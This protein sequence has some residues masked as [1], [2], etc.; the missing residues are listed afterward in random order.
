MA[1]NPYGGLT[2]MIGMMLRADQQEQL[3]EFRQD[4]L[5][6]RRE[7][8][9]KNRDFENRR[10]GILETRNKVD[11]D[12]LEINQQVEEDRQKVSEMGFRNLEASKLVKQYVGVDVNGIPLIDPSTGRLD[13]NAIIKGLEGRHPEVDALALLTIRNAGIAKELQDLGFL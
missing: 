12:Q 5:D 4:D 8:A 9:Q 1:T 10:L 13:T 6:F 3:L 2:S 11:Q 7:E